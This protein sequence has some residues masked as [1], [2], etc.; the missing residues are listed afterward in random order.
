MIKNL[1]LLLILI[2]LVSAIV[3]T[4]DHRGVRNSGDNRLPQMDV[5]FTV[6]C[7]TKT[8]TAN[9]LSEEG[10]IIPNANMY[11]FYTDYGYQP[12]ASARTN[13]NGMGQLHIVGNPNY[14]TALF[15]LKTESPSYQSQEIEFTYEKCFG[16]VSDEEITNPPPPPTLPPE[17]TTNNTGPTPV[18]PPPVNNTPVPNNTVN[19]TNN[20][21]PVQH[22]T[23]NQTAQPEP[24]SGCK[25][26]FAIFGFVLVGAVLLNKKQ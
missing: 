23:S 8:I 24:S 19:T 12:I 13:Q 7:P 25:M 3:V 6:D 26:P 10:D 4:P 1:F 18:P 20:T 11:V 9:V 15:I 5:D 14:L 22:N 21:P 17:N 2:G 16:T